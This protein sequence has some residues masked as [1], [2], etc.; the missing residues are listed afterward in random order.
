MVREDPH[1]PLLVAEMAKRDPIALGVGRLRPVVALPDEV[2]RKALGVVGVR[3]PVRHEADVARELVGALLAVPEEQLVVELVEALR[4]FER[5][6]VFRI[7]GEAHAEAV[8]LDAPVAG[9]VRRVDILFNAG[10]ESARPVSLDDIRVNAVHQLV[11]APSPLD[12][13]YGLPVDGVRLAPYGIGDSRRRHEIAFVR[14]VD[15]HARAV[16]GPSLHANRAYAAAF[17][18]HSAFSA[19]EAFALHHAYSVPLHPALEDG[20]RRRRLE[21]P[22]GVR[23]GLETP[24]ARRL[25]LRGVFAARLA[26]P[27][28]LVAVPRGDGFVE[29]A[30]YASVGLLVADVGASESAGGESADSARGLY[31]DHVYPHPLRL[32][33]GRDSGGRSA[34]HDEIEWLRSLGRGWC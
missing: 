21:A 10:E 4:L 19:V 16:H 32:H 29:L 7:V 33:C 27:M 5:Y 28:R 2:E 14:R 31:Q 9:S 34:V 24:V 26:R 3:L 30:R 20:E 11:A 17:Q 6:P 15:E 1:E 8:R 18:N 23:L 22:H 25:H 13:V 12:S